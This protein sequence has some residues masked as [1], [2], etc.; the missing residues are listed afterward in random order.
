LSVTYLIDFQVVPAKRERFLALLNGVLDAMRSE[1]TFRDA[2][3]HVDPQDQNHFLLH[4]TWADH[5]EVVAVQIKRPYRDDWHEALPQ[6]LERPRGISIW[7]PLR[8]DRAR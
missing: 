8:C 5:D 4:E 3:L 7:T 2:T 1:A 6:L